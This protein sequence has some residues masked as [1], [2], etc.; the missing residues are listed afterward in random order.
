ME[1]RT[2]RKGEREK[3][4]GGERSKVVVCVNRLT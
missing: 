3:G 2:E 4:K 1:E